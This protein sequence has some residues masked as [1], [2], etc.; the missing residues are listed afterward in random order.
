[1]SDDYYVYLLVDHDS[2]GGSSDKIFYVG[3]GR[4]SR[5]LHHVLEYVHALER[6]NFDEAR[7]AL[8]R[9]AATDDDLDGHQQPAL[10]HEKVRRIA[11]IR[12]AGREVRIDVLRAGLNSATAYA[13]ESAAIDVLG[14]ANLAN[15]IAG[16]DHFRAPASAVSRM[17]DAQPVHITEPALQ[18]TV[19]GLWGGASVAGLVDATDP[20]IILDNARQSWSIGATRRAR[21]SMAATTATPV[22]LVAVSKGPDQL[23]GGI[24]LGV[25]ELIGTQPSS[26]RTCVR[27]DG[28]TYQT[29][30]WEFLRAEQQSPRLAALRQQ[31]LAQPRRSMHPRQVGPT[32]IEL[33]STS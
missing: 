4:N 21:I 17:L 14:V 2:R 10:E 26:P 18:V 12:R 1:M 16:H 15:K 31:W 24:I 33:D 32:G 19:A 27:Q 8:T 13:D 7:K 6:E 22:L 29:A 25:W 3:K 9:A 11:E 23:W 5:A 28:T 30:G 20:Q